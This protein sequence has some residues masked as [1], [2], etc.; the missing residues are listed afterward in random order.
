MVYLH[1]GG[2]IRGSRVTYDRTVKSMAEHSG[3]VVVSVEYRLLPCPEEPMA[4]FED[5]LAATRWVM[6]HRDAL[7]GAGSKVGI[8]GDSAGGQLVLG[9][10]HDIQSGLDFMMLVYPTADFNLGLPSCE[11]FHNIP[12]LSTA[13][14]RWRFG[15]TNKPIPDAENNPRLNAAVRQDLGSLPPAVILLAQLDPLRDAGTN[16]AEKLKSAGVLVRLHTLEGVPHGF[17]SMPGVYTTT[18][19]QAYAHISDF[20]KKFQ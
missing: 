14:L 20:L 8:G 4:P 7:G 18:T 3:V 17:F 19:C 16:L 12:G 9:V 5:A 1:G 13:G 2:L 15:I 11:E 10:T 6:K